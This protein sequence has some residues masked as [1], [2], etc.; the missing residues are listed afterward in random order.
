MAVL[1]A[2][3]VAALIILLAAPCKHANAQAYVWTNCILVKNGNV[4]VAV[5]LAQNA[6]QCTA[7]ARQCAEGSTFTS[8]NWFD[9]AR[10]VG[11]PIQVCTPNPGI[12]GRPTGSTTTRCS[13]RLSGNA[14]YSIPEANSQRECSARADSCARVRTGRAPMVTWWDPNGM[15]GPSALCF[16][17]PSTPPPAPAPAR[18]AEFWFNNQCSVPVSLIV[19]YERMDGVWTHGDF[20]LPPKRASWLLESP[21]ERMQTLGRNWYFYADSKHERWQGDGTHTHLMGDGTK[22]KLRKMSRTGGTVGFT[23]QCTADVRARRVKPSDGSALPGRA[24]LDP[25]LPRP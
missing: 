4:Q 10:L 22:V 8:A 24:P 12:I 16:E 17:Q 13:T 14:E 15:S 21:T 25:S 1:R 6:Q 7:Y 11:E 23:F 19:V 20:E 3:G 18:G 9:S 5:R 2:I